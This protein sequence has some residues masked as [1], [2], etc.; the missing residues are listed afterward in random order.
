MISGPLSYRSSSLATLFSIYI[1]TRKELGT[2][3]SRDFARA[4]AGELSSTITI[5]FGR[6]TMGMINYL[7][8]GENQL[9]ST[10]APFDQGFSRNVQ[11]SSDPVVRISRNLAEK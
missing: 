7:V 10:H 6:L 3:C 1:F 2:R 4:T 8:I 11:I 9:S 5:F